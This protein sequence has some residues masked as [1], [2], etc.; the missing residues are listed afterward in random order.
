MNA[1]QW[2][3]KRRQRTIRVKWL[4]ADENR[5]E[6][7]ALKTHTNIEENGEKRNIE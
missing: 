7:E 2:T 5:Y 3:T 4:S 1:R 6:F